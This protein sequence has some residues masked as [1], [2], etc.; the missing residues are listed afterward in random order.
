MEINYL[1]V[2]IILLSIA[3][4]TLKV[5]NTSSRGELAIPAPQHDFEWFSL[6]FLFF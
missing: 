4:V 6:D 2:F 5:L 3:I 1:L